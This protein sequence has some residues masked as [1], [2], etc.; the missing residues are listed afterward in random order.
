[1]ADTLQVGLR[2]EPDCY[3]RLRAYAND[4]HW[5]VATAA[6]IIVCD[7]LDGLDAQEEKQA[8]RNAPGAQPG[9]AKSA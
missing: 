3:D 4:H 2:L 6:R 1:M 8:S 9:G 5:A 7:Y